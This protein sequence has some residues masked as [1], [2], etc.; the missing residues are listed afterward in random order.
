MDFKEIILILIG[1][2][3]AVWGLVTLNTFVGGN[4]LFAFIG[5]P[6]ILGI[7]ALILGGGF[8]YFVYENYAKHT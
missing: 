6:A 3:I 8:T 4:S 2:I 7:G 1:L 5:T